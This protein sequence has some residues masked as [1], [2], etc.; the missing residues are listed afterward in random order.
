MT[1]TEAEAKAALS[2]HGLPVP[3]AVRADRA[4]LGAK[5]RD[6]GFPLVL[7]SEGIAHK[8]EAGGVALNLADAQA[9]TEAAQNMPG[10]QFLMEEMITDT[11]VEL[12]IGVVRD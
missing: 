4:D 11:V 12:L 9:V 3:R 6:V 8:T 2:G 7:K 10:T 5:S 1:L